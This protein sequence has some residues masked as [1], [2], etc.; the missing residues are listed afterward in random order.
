MKHFRY[1][2]LDAVLAPFHLFQFLIFQKPQEDGKGLG[3]GSGEAPRDLHG[4]L[5]VLREA[6]N[7]GAYLAPS[8]SRRPLR[9]LLLRE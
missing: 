5:S 6:L 7:S 2:T 1:I 9:K 8:E 3:P 4:F